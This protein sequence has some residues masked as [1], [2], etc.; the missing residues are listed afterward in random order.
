MPLIRALHLTYFNEINSR[1][2]TLTRDSRVSTCKIS[3][4][5]MRVT[6]QIQ[7]S[8][9]IDR[10]FLIIQ[11]T[12][13]WPRSKFDPSMKSL[14]LHLSNDVYHVFINLVVGKL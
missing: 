8:K 4:R 3:Q 10:G 9:K 14:G 11:S 5:F 12:Y 2:I 13:D 6:S 7:N 1:N